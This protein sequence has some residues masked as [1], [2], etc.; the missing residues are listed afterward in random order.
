MRW[1]TGTEICT[2]CGGDA[3]SGLPFGGV[4]IIDP[5]DAPII[6]LPLDATIID[7]WRVIQRLPPPDSAPW[8]QFVVEPQAGGE[9]AL[10]TLYRE[11]CEPDSAVYNVLRRM[12]RDHIPE[13][14]A[15]GR[16]DGRAFDVVEFV[17]G[18]SLADGGHIQASGPDLVGT[19][20][21]ELGAA[22]AEFADAG[23]RHR[24]LRPKTILL[25]QADPLDLVVTGFSSARLS[26]FDLEA[27]APLKLTRYSAPEAIV[28]A[29]S[30]ASDWWSLG[31]V[32]LECA[33]RGACFEGVN[34]Q[35][36]LIHVVT[37]GMDLPPD[38]PPDISLLLRGLLARDP[39]VRWSWPQVRAWLNGELVEAPDGLRPDLED[40]TPI[41]L[42]GR[43]YRN[44]ETYALAAAEAAN[45]DEA[46]NLILRGA[47]ARWLEERGSGRRVVAEVRQVVADHDLP[48]D[49][50]HAL[51]LMAA[52]Q[53]LPLVLSGEIV[54]PAWLL[55]DPDR[56]YDFV[57]GP[58]TRHLERMGRETWL[59][60]LR[61]RA[62]AVRERA[63]VLEI[64]LDDARTRVA[65]LATSRANLEA[66][67]DRLPGPLSGHGAQR[68]RLP[69]GAQ[70]HLRRGSHHSGERRCFAVCAAPTAG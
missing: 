40:G 43:E 47:L 67:R 7:G 62:E 66:E 69:D 50:R 51:A 35:A 65:L 20:A 33:T 21:K 23:L 22:L 18:S 17:T 26:D 14:L 48:E 16:H 36:F 5:D 54:T 53:D 52:A 24:D 29:V 61:S 70:P 63:R 46:H 39:L 31:M 42:A 6:P 9:P 2:V 68:S 19:L 12:H 34:D 60:G 4:T 3:A 25:R 11:D 15:T 30:A 1:R 64:E 38:L 44:P 37:R 8:E 13:L 55:S 41:T 57:T 49:H 45:W 10:L 27:V 32:V 59:V 56:G 58:V 28:G